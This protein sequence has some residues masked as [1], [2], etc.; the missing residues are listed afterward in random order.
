[1]N[2]PRR[3]LASLNSRNKCRYCC[4]CNL[5]RREPGRARFIR[6]DLQAGQPTVAEKVATQQKPHDQLVSLPHLKE[7]WVCHWNPRL[8]RTPTLTK[9]VTTIQVSKNMICCSATAKTIPT[10]MEQSSRRLNKT[11]G[12]RV[13]PK[14]CGQGNYMIVARKNIS[15]D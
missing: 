12:C 1:M 3:L 15:F 13:L 14:P 11:H 2:S 7:S 5:F 9:Q 10:Q 6:L 4:C 8:Y